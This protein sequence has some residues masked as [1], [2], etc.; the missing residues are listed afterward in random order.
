MLLAHHFGLA[1]V[2]QWLPLVLQR[3]CGR[4]SDIGMGV[5]KLRRLYNT[6]LADA[7]P[8]L[9]EVLGPE[10]SALTIAATSGAT[11]SVE[12]DAS[13]DCLNES[14][15]LTVVLGLIHPW[16]LFI[17]LVLLYQLPVRHDPSRVIWRMRKR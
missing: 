13:S 1:F 8:E 11:N 14:E 3:Y 4:K 17:Y 12:P 6:I 2:L 7:A 5:S 10:G 9:E 15:F 16:L